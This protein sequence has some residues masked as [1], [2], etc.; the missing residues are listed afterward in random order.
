MRCFLAI[1]AFAS[2]AVAPLSSAHAGVYGD[3]LSRCL[4]K[5]TT[6]ED[7]VAFMI[8]MFSALGSHPAVKSYTTFTDAQRDAAS[9]KAAGLMQRLMVED[10]RKETIA[11][12]RYEG[13]TAV[14]SAFNIFGQAAVRDL[15]TDPAVTKS[16]EALGEHVDETKFEALAKEAGQAS[17]SK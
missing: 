3:D 8:W 15:M 6:S 10:C 2:L 9:A 7:Q 1:A 5:S 14:L 4:V 11:G 12:I 17:T 16:L 13:Q